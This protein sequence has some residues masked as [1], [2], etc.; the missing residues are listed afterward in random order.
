MHSPTLDLTA[1]TKAVV[2]SV[3]ANVILGAS[4]IYWKA[5]SSFTPLALL[6]YRILFS[7]LTLAIIL[8]FKK[9]A[10]TLVKKISLKLLTVHVFAAAF[11]VINWGTFIWASIHGHILES[12]LGYLLA[13]FVAIAVGKLVL[14]DKTTTATS[15]AL[16]I[17]ALTVGYLFNTEGDLTHW[18]YLTIGITWGGYACLKK[19]TTLDSFSGLFVETA[20]LAMLIPLILIVLPVTLSSPAGTS[21]SELALLGLCGLFSVIPLTL[22][23]FAAS[24]LP[25]SLMGFFQFILPLTQLFIALA[26]YRQSTSPSTLLCFSIIGLSLALIMMKSL[27]DNRNL[28]KNES[29]PLTPK[30]STFQIKK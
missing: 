25:L 1:G 24:R 26:V 8:L 12:G 13:P 29:L 2:A 14:G 21:N 15:I 30:S 6:C 20:V 18:V 23:S 17:I 22:F 16:V 3:T 10:L 9:E 19:W 7:L 5:L 27:L 4:S 11:V 28:Q